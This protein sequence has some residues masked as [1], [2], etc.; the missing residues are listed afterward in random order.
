M[1][2]TINEM[3]TSYKL[4]LVFSIL[5]AVM[6]ILL[7]GGTG[8]LGAVIWFYIAWL[9]YKQDNEKLI[10]CE[11]TL[12]WVIAIS[13]ILVVFIFNVTKYDMEELVG[14]TDLEFIIIGVIGFIVHFLLLKFFTNQMLKYKNQAN[15]DLP[16][17]KNSENSLA[18]IF[19]VL[20]SIFFTLSLNKINTHNS[21]KISTYNNEKRITD[22]LEQQNIHFNNRVVTGCFDYNG[23]VKLGITQSEIINFVGRRINFDVEGAKKAGYSEEEIYRYLRYGADYTTSC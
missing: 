20:M 23:A 15:D 12:V 11:K 5:M 18:I 19:L 6:S 17:W 21:N 8:G 4:L 7:S 13:F 22:F 9:I 16:Y 14:V 10:S 3:N 2:K 1:T